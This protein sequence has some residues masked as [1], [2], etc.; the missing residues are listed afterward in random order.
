VC[1]YKFT[2]LFN[3]VNLNHHY[4][5]ITYTTGVHAMCNTF[6]AYA[7]NNF[8]IGFNCRYCYNTSIFRTYIWQCLLPFTNPL[9]VSLMSLAVFGK[10]TWLITQEASDTRLIL[11]KAVMICSTT[12]VTTLIAFS[13]LSSLV[14]RE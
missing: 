7:T 4:L 14:L 10:M 2:N 13:V 1:V 11:V 9:V 5:R 3:K 6:R 12:I 8:C